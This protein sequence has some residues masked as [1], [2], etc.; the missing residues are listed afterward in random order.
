MQGEH[1]NPEVSATGERSAKFVCRVIFTR[2]SMG[3]MK[4]DRLDTP[5]LGVKA[6]HPFTSRQA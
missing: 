1:R 6:S 4:R 3:P 2:E 5:A